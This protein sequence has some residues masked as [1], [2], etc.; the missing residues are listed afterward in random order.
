MNPLDHTTPE[1][2]F[3]AATL[4]DR[5]ALRKAYARLIKRFDPEHHPAAFEHIRRLYEQARSG[6]SAQPARQAPSP[7][8]T[9]PFSVDRWLGEL[10]A[11]RYPTAIDSLRSHVV[12]SGDPDSAMVLFACLDATAPD[13]VPALIA[14]LCRNPELQE[15]VCVSFARESLGLRPELVRDPAWARACGA[16]TNG[17][18]LAMLGAARIEA[19]QQLDHPA[20]MVAV[21]RELHHRI[22][23]LAP[24]AYAQLV[25][26]VL[27]QGG[28]ELDAT[29]LNIIYQGLSQYDFQAE[30]HDVALALDHLCYLRTWRAAHADPNVPT[31]FLDCLRLGIHQHD[32][33]AVVLLRDLSEQ[34]PGD[35]LDALLDHLREQWPQL[36]ARLDQLVARATGRDAWLETFVRSPRPPQGKGER[37][38]LQLPRVMAQLAR[39]P[40][41]SEPAVKAPINRVNRLLVFLG[42]ATLPALGKGI[43]QA[44]HMPELSN[45]LLFVLIGGGLAAAA[46]A[47]WVAYKRHIQATVDARAVRE[48]SPEAVAAIW[49]AARRDRQEQ[50]LWSH[51]LAG[52]L[53]ML[54]PEAAHD[55]VEAMMLDRTTD[56]RCI[57]DAHYRTALYRHACAMSEPEPSSPS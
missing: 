48:G 55:K 54:A 40:L 35:R 49:A 24:D 31:A 10:T 25:L 57:R 5:R 56:L 45:E 28:F 19:W 7:A 33:P 36:L 27:Q 12:Q 41:S 13:E 21:F 44:E 20:G 23:P 32:L 11:D 1:D 52:L 14:E 34:L 2:L 42:M 22:R 16:V 53:R 46:G 47:V 26:R 4:G 43:F 9:P 50:G 37:T 6:A 51:D 39:T 15:S 17:W 29:L 3:G 30:E 18:V 8:S 38:E